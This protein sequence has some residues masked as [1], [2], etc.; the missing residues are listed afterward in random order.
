M[1]KIT[2][3]LVIIISITGLLSGIAY[4]TTVIYNNYIKNN[5]NHKVTI[6]PTFQSTLDEGTPNENTP[7]ETK[8]DKRTA[9]N[10]WVGTLDLAWKELK[11]R[12]NLSTIEIEGGNSQIVK[13]LNESTF[14]KKMLDQN[15][16]EINVERTF[17]NGY[18]IDAI[19]NKK[20]NFLEP[21]DNFSQDYTH[22]TFGNN[23]EYIK[24]FGINAGSSE[25]MNKNIEILFYNTADD[26]NLYTIYGRTASKDIAIKLKTKEGD[27]II[28]YRTNEKKSFEEYYDDIQTK[29]KAYTGSKEFSKDDQLEIPY[30]RINGMINYDELYGKEIRNSNGLYIYDVNQYVNFSLNEKGCNLSSKATMI[31]E[32]EGIVGEP[33][34]FY[35]TDTFILFMKE[36]DSDKPYFALKVDN[37]DILEKVEETDEPKILDQTMLSG[38]SN[39]KIEERRI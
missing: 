19:L 10:V 39:V 35:F 6:N 24:Y 8:I 30:I 28:L 32:P 34:Y 11:E 29:A 17:L 3:V 15:D 14:T 31:I 1:N 13:D 2:K 33:K 26:K 21:F 23:Q 5:T 36:K 37:S 7:N 4:A 38:N 25:K 16:Y 9:N 20:L 12:I 18:K 27:E 22:L